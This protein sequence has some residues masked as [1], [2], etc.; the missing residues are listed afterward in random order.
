MN[1]E[2]EKAEGGKKEE[3]SK[4]KDE[5]CQKGAKPD[6]EANNSTCKERGGRRWGMIDSGWKEE[7]REKRKKRPLI[8]RKWDQ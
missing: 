4:N 8:P 6:K 2:G 5:R 3:V 7:T 1:R